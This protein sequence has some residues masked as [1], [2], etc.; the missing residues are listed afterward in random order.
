MDDLSPYLEVMK[1]AWNH[2]KISGTYSFRD[3]D[4]GRNSFWDDIPGTIAHNVYSGNNG[5]AHLVVEKCIDFLGAA[6]NA[7]DELDDELF[8]AKLLV[9]PALKAFKAER[10]N[11]QP[12]ET[13]VERTW[14]QRCG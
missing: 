9:A 7:D 3:D 12:V 13:R 8:H 14:F 1:S 10:C 5:G 4:D 11:L 6:D 2:S